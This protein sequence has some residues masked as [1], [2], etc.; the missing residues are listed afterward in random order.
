M[1]LLNVILSEHGGQAVKSLSKQFGISQKDAE[2]AIG[3]LVP[4]LANG[5][6]QN[7]TQS[8]GVEQLMK[9]LQSGNHAKYLDD[10]E[11]LEDS[12]SEAEG[13]AIL[14]HIFGSKDVSRAVAKDAAAQTGLGQELLKKML[15]AIAT[16]AMGA[17]S[18]KTQDPSLGSLMSG[19]LD[20][21]S[22]SGNQLGA[23]SSLLDTKGDG[24]IAEG[25]LGLAE[26]LFKK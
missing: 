3:R 25:A 13:N 6:S 1:S 8:G 5:L 21:G 20:S 24:S 23:L 14:G 16:M 9:A 15:P 2:N 19:V 18:K 4:S 7:S 26:R 17:L 11:V 12:R 22:T 10:P